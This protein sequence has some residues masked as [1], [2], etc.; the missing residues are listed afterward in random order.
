MKRLHDILLLTLSLAAVMLI[1]GCSNSDK[2]EYIDLES[3]QVT[4]GCEEYSVALGDVLSIEPVI[5]S[6]I[7]PTDLSYS[8]EVG[9]NQI[10]AGNARF[11]P[12]ATTRDLAYRCELSDQFP[13][14]GRYTVR[15]HVKQI[16]ADRDF[17]S[18]HFTINITGQ[19][20]VMVLYNVADACDIALIKGDDSVIPNFYSSSNDG[21]RIPGKGKWLTQLRGGN[22]GVGN[23]H[24][25]LAITDLGSVAAHY[26][27]MEGEHD[28]WN[29]SLFLGSFNKGIPEGISYIGD[30]PLSAY[31]N[32]YIFDGGE[33]YGRQASQYVLRPALGN[34]DNAYAQGFD[35]FPA[36]IA[37]GNGARY[38]LW[39][40]DRGSRAF[41]GITNIVGVFM[42][43]P[44][45]VSSVMKVFAPGGAFNPSR[46]RALMLHMGLGGDDRHI[47]AVMKRD[48]GDKFVAE[49]DMMPDDVTKTA[50]NLYELSVLDGIAE[51]DKFAYSNL[52]GRRVYYASG[53]R[54]LS[55]VLNTDGSITEA[56]EIPLSGAD[57]GPI[58]EI[59]TLDVIQLNGA[60]HLAVGVSSAAGQQQSGALYI[61]RL[62]SSTALPDAQSVYTLPGI[63]SAVE[64]KHI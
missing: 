64:V 13:A 54:L 41:I 34:T 8:W 33:V 28:G 45:D 22:P 57:F 17:Y 49:I 21:R 38:Q 24:S 25:V 12:F 52:T 55:C 44:A 31:Q 20:G 35:L 14:P 32:V 2:F 47:F 59:T 27:T 30:D 16:S 62:S 26:I 42:N 15:L 48:G 56:G 39:L 6:N 63:P 53:E 9:Y 19:T 46:M 58:A 51:A 4:I 11:T 23:Y 1:G 7:Q 3:L 29:S 60:P 61:L 10:G 5:T 43:G 36:A 50:A 40:F 37:A 18:S